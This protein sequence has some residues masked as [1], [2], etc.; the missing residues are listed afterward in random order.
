MVTQILGCRFVDEPDRSARIDYE[1]AFAQSAGR[2]TADS[3][4][5]LSE[6][7]IA[8]GQVPRSRGC[9]RQRRHTSA[10]RSTGSRRARL[11]AVKSPTE[12]VPAKCAASLRMS[13]A[14]ARAPGRRMATA[15]SRDQASPLRR[16]DQQNAETTR[17]TTAAVEEQR[18]PA[19]SAIC[20]EPAVRGSA[21]SVPQRRNHGDAGGE[22]RHDDVLKSSRIR[23]HPTLGRVSAGVVKRGRAISGTGEPVKRFEKT[24]HATPEILCRVPWF[25]ASLLR[26]LAGGI[27]CRTLPCPLAQAKIAAFHFQAIAGQ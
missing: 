16:T 24:E 1:D 15:Q 2:W 11:P 14:I 8:G 12:A 19:T 5:R 18:D 3:S 22:V 7:H 9:V 20:T 13:N 10:Q 6:I 4:A 21:R 27:G 17:D 26:L 23:R 25:S